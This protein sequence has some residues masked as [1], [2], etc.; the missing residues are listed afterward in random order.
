MNSISW[1][2][3]SSSLSYHCNLFFMY[4]FVLFKVSRLSMA[5][6]FMMMAICLG[7]CIQ[8]RAQAILSYKT[9]TTANAKDRTMIL[10][11]LRASL[12]QAHQQEFIFVVRK[13]NVTSTHAWF[14]GDV[15]RKDGKKVIYSVDDDCCHVE[16]LLKRSGGKWYIVDMSSFSTDV[17]WENIWTRYGLP[18]RM[19]FE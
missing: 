11:V 5:K 2:S 3:L 15:Q 17:W 8:A 9:K 14:E 16:A 12:Y 18:R 13:L 10:D 4:P 6:I 1:Y 19:F 7:F